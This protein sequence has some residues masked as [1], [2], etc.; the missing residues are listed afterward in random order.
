MKSAPDSVSPLNTPSD[1]GEMGELI[2]SFD[3]ANPPLGPIDSWSTSLKMM[4][5]FLLA[6]RFPLLL[7]WGPEF[8]Q[9]YNDPYRPVLGAKHP[10][11]GLGR[12][13]S[14]CWSEIWHILRPLIETPFSGGPATWMEDIM[15]EL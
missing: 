11:P 12:P 5:R 13:V 4:V 7:W 3:W 8:I 6:N 1:A 14:E 15:L 2:Q 10:A 9:I